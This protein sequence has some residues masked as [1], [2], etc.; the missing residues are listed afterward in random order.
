MRNLRKQEAPR[1]S[2]SPEPK[3]K[4]NRAAGRPE[5]WFGLVMLVMCVLSAAA[6]AVNL[7]RVNAA[8]SGGGEEET[9]AVNTGDRSMKNDQY[10]IGNN[11]TEVEKTCFQELT[12]ALKAKD[13]M[14]VCEAVA[15]NFVADYF[16]WTNKDGNYEVGGLQYIYGP[17]YAVFEEFSRYTYYSDLDLYISQYGRD[18]LLQVKE[19]KL[20]KPVEKAPDFSYSVWTD[21]TTKQDVMFESYE[22]NVSWTYENCKLNTS[23]FVDGARFFL[24][25][26]NGRWEIA[27]F[28]DYDSIHEWEVENGLAAT[29]AEG[30]QA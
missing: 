13:D 10:Q 4:K 2:A 22:V 24:I 7:V 5:T 25:N 28:Y 18:N 11:P 16:T 20:D 27:E 3:V 1:R 14:A 6:L 30:G 12:N 29:A 9:I 26:N 17:K 21:E 15:K 23:D 19:V 8:K